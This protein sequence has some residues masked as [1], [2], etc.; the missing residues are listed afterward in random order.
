M[1]ELHLHKTGVTSGTTVTLDLPD[2]SFPIGGEYQVCVSSKEFNSTCYLRSK[3]IVGIIFIV[4][5]L[6]TNLVKLGLQL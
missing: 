2:D 5:K 1:V 3:N 6:Y 4:I